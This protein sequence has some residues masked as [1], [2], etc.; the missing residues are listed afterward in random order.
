M[1]PFVLIDLTY[2]AE[3][4]ITSGSFKKLSAI[5][6]DPRLTEF[7]SKQG[8]LVACRMNERGG[9]IVVTVGLNGIFFLEQKPNDTYV[10]AQL[11]FICRTAM[12]IE[13]QGKWDMRDTYR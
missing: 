3:F 4:M 12:E 6:A 2:K 13:T 9:T 11:I 5:V 7:E 10:N 8:D 1:A